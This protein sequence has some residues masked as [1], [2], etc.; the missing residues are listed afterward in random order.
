MLHQKNADARRYPAS[1]TKMMT[2]YI[3]FEELERGRYRLSSN[4]TAT[5]HSAS[6]PPSKLGLRPGETIS[7]EDAIKALVTKS[8]ND[9]ASTIGENISGSESAFA[10]RMTRTARAIGMR[11]T[12]F[13]NASGL[14]DERQYTTA[15]DMMTL[16]VALQVRFPRYFDYFQTR[17]FVWK[18]RTIGNHNRLLGNV[19]GVDGIK[20]GYTRMSGFNLVTSVQR[21]GRKVVAVVLGGTSGRWRDD[22]MRELIAAYMPKARRGRGVDDDLIASAVENKV[23][24]AA[25]NIAIQPKM[26][27]SLGKHPLPPARPLMPQQ[28][29][30]TASILPSA[31]ISVQRAVKVLPQPAPD[32]YVDRSLPSSAAEA[33]AEVDEEPSAM[34]DAEMEG[35]DSALPVQTVS[36]PLPPVPVADVIQPSKSELAALEQLPATVPAAPAA[37]AAQ[38]G[39]SSKWLIQ[40]GS[41]PSREA[42]HSLLAK[43]QDKGGRVLA[44]ADPMTEVFNKGKSTF[45]RARFAG[46]DD[47]DAAKNACA[48][49]KKKDFAC[50]AIRS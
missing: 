25:R 45:Y 6:M 3:L 23:P 35:E 9:V 10:D 22:R 8:A 27:A 18:G 40:I 4:L 47:G 26:V 11:G 1:L 28:E 7:V 32:A 30:T 15:R 5:Q 50:F 34:G 24:V 16:G 31:T 39:S 21:D 12:R 36:V 49:L 42:A 19:E 43:A 13:R 14:P 48:L 44:N 29:I 17:R 33:F 20:T 37:S 46:F 2:L 41:L 38:S